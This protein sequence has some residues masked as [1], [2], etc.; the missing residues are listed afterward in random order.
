MIMMIF[1]DM[2]KEK[3]V[4]KNFLYLAAPIKAYQIFVRLSI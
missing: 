1:L 4:S 3:K 2:D